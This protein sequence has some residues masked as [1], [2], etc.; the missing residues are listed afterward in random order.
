MPYTAQKPPLPETANQLR[1]RIPGWGSDLDPEDRPSMPQERQ[2]VTGAHW[3]LP[4]RQPGGSN[5]ERSIEHIGMPAAFGATIPLTGLSGKVRLLAY[6]RF[7]EARA[8]HWLLLLAG[9]RIDVAE[10]RVK[11]LVQVQ[12][13]EPFAETGIRAELRGH[14]FRS[15]TGARRADVK[16]AWLDP[17]VTAGPTLLAVGAVVFVARALLRRA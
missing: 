11:A 12:P 5:R 16:H 1:A 2:E 14:G 17:V 3:T 10:S 15:R 7:S 4:E 13:D 6:D 8:A 9:D